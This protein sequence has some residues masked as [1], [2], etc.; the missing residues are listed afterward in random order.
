MQYA[1]SEQVAFGY[2]TGGKKKDCY[3]YY[4][5]MVLLSRLTVEVRR[6]EVNGMCQ[7]HE[8]WSWEQRRQR[9]RQ[10]IFHVLRVKHG[11]WVCLYYCI[12]HVTLYFMGTY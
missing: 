4:Y 7:D 11:Q 9:K 2:Q 6:V 3:V 1:K 8:V 10:S 5:G 12:V